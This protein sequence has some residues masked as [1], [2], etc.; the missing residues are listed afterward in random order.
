MHWKQYIHLILNIYSKIFSQK[1][2]QRPKELKQPSSREQRYT[3]FVSV[4]LDMIP[5]T[6]TIKEKRVNHIQHNTKVFVFQEKED[7]SKI[8]GKLQF[9]YL[10]RNLSLES[11]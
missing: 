8:G 1:S 7:Y 5:N 2:Y 4:S 9:M 10:I 11:V 6:Q 3:E